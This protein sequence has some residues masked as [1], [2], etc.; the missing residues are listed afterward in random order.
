MREHAIEQF[1]SASTAQRPVI[2]WGAIFGGWLFAYAFALLLYLLGAAAGITS[3]AAINNWSNA[4]TFGTGLWM[5]A[6]WVIATFTGAYFAGRL[7]GAAS[8]GSGMMHGM[9]VWALSGL[10]TIF[11]GS[12]QAAG[13]ASAGVAAGQ[14]IVSFGQEAGQQGGQVAIPQ[15]IRQ[16][17]ADQIQTQSSRIIA[18]APGAQNVSQQE[19]RQ[20]MEQLDQQ[21]YTEIGSALIRGNSQQARQILADNTTLSESQI[22]SLVNGLTASAE[23]YQNQFAQGAGQMAETAGDYAGLTLWVFFFCSLLGLGAGAWGGSLGAV[24]AARHQEVY[25][26]QN[27]PYPG[28]APSEAERRRAG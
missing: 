6:A 13:V 21:N 7:S 3:L 15:E 18:Q 5:I 11:L 24:S 23:N 10:M 4:V 9:L 2:S 25:W 19:I 20:A 27:R 1:E 16:S 14:G 8:T 17:F 12:L 22:T 28:T 26:I